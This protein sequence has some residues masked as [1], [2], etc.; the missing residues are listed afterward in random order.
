SMSNPAGVPAR[1][2][3]LLAGRRAIIPGGCPSGDPRSTRESSHHPCRTAG[4]RCGDCGCRPWPQRTIR[5]SVMRRGKTVLDRNIIPTPPDSAAAPPVA[6]ARALGAA[7]AAL[8]RGE[9]VLIRDADISVL[10]IAAELAT[11]ANLARLREAARAP[12][13]VVL[14]RRR[15]VALGLA[16]R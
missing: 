3:V 5:G 15:A 9:P 4:Q 1:R 6:S 2:P 13:R 10:T 12:A 14:T 7:V 8:R 11:E 16:P